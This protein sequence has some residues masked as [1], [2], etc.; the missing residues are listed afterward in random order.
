MSSSVE[1]REEPLAADVRRAP[2]I[3]S[4]KLELDG[5]PLAWYASIR[6]TKEG[7]QVILLRL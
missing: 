7:E 4:P 5:A 3:W 2:R 1:S 6:N